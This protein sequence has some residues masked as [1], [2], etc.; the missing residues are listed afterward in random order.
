M[1]KF[2]TLTREILNMRDIF[3]QLKTYFF[4]SDDLDTF[5]IDPVLKLE[6]KLFKTVKM[7]MHIL[8]CFN[9]TF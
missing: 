1:L 2:E 4:N 3:Q 7:N 9:L 5:K 8:E 6:L